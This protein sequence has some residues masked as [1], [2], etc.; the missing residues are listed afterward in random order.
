V[1]TTSV[2]STADR[3]APRDVSGVRPPCALTMRCGTPAISV[4]D[5]DTPSR[6][7]QVKWRW[8]NRGLA[9]RSRLHVCSRPR[10][11]HV[12]PGGGSRST[13]IARDSSASARGFFAGSL[14]SHTR[15][16]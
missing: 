16:S 12:A 13:A 6:E 15:T 10:T 7:G 4:S 11:P 8:S 3:V 2:R 1:V 9:R 5:R 14:A